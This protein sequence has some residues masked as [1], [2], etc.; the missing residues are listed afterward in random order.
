MDWK[1][2]N[3]K[4]LSEV[5]P[6]FKKTSI[7]PIGSKKKEHQ[8]SAKKRIPKDVLSFVQDKGNREVLQQ[9]INRLDGRD[10]TINRAQQEEAFTREKDKI[11]TATKNGVTETMDYSPEEQKQMIEEDP[12]NIRL[13]DNPPEAIQMAAVKKEGYTIYYIKNPSDDVKLAAINQNPK[14]IQYIKNPSEGLQ[15]IAVNLN[16]GAIY[17]IDHPTE[18]ALLLALE[19]KP[20]LALY[21]REAVQTPAVMER[22]GVIRAEYHRSKKK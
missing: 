7:E 21:L 15:L 19:K 2:T 3:I 8:E 9:H 17:K 20:R 12:H 10:Q 5:D 4:S 18:K 11:E 6:L 16:P 13:I 22:V 1:K 14:S